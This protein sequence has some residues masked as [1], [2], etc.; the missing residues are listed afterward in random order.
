MK[1]ELTVKISVNGVDAEITGDELS[2]MIY[3][4][5]LFE[6]LAFE[7]LVS[8]SVAIQE[9]QGVL[10][11]ESTEREKIEKQLNLVKGAVKKLQNISRE[12]WLD[13]NR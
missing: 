5:D 12:I 2:K 3:F 4:I 6:H 1:N 10:D 7:G 13:Q 11:S 9:A 8:M